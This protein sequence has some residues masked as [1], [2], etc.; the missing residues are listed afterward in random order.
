MPIGNAV[1]RGNIIYVYDDRNRQIFTISAGTAPGD[2]LKGYT[3]ARVN[4]R[5]GN[6]IYSYDERGRQ[7]GTTAAR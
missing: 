3:G 5:R 1:Q 6:I 4:V 7:A 2:G